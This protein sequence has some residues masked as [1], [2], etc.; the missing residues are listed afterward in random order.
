MAIWPKFD[1]NHWNDAS[2]IFSDLKNLEKVV[3]FIIL[4][5]WV[6]YIKI[7]SFFLAIWTNLT[8]NQWNNTIIIITGPKNLE[9]MV[10]VPIRSN[11]SYPATNWIFDFFTWM[12]R[13]FHAVFHAVFNFVGNWLFN[14]IKIVFQKFLSILL[15]SPLYDRFSYLTIWN[16]PGKGWA[17]NNW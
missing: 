16:P 2:I 11:S 17:F 1:S 12:H 6:F 5:I 3:S 13:V 10:S 14:E 9:K 4:P 8:S 7:T 15:T